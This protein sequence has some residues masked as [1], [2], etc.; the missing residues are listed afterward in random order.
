[1]LIETSYGTHKLIRI[2]SAMNCTIVVEALE[3]HR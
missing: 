1:M 3:F 2:H